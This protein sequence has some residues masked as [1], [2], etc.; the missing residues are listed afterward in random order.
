MAGVFRRL[1]P[2]PAFSTHGSAHHPAVCRSSGHPDPLYLYTVFHKANTV[3]VALA[4]PYAGT[5]QAVARVRSMQDISPHVQCLEWVAVRRKLVA[6]VFVAEARLPWQ[7][8]TTARAEPERAP[9][10]ASS[11]NKMCQRLVAGPG[12]VSRVKKGAEMNHIMCRVRTADSPVRRGSRRVKGGVFSAV[13]GLALPARP[14]RFCSGRRATIRRTSCGPHELCTVCVCLV[15]FLY[16]RVSGSL[17]V[18]MRLR[19][20]T[21][22]QVRSSFTVPASIGLLVFLATTTACLPLLYQAL[23]A[24]SLAA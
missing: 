16:A 8:H 9:R 7:C 3:S 14:W 10:Y 2:N 21:K 17:P 6:F 13:L 15:L 12:G 18:A 5:S 19:K 20:Q 23:P 22:R 24:T 11:G 4:E 1:V